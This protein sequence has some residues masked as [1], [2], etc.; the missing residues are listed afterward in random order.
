MPFGT[1]LSLA[2][3]LGELGLGDIPVIFITAGNEPGL[4]DA[5]KRLGAVGFFEKPYDVKELLAA[6]AE[7][8]Q[9]Q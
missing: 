2:Q 6:I 1:G 8:L 9:N 3:R 4:Q 7:I 5:A